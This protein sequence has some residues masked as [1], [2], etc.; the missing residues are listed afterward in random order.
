MVMETMMV[1]GDGVHDDNNVSKDSEG[2]HDDRENGDSEYGCTV[3][4]FM[5]MVAMSVMIILN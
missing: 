1:I 2:D 3:T 5:I 4:V